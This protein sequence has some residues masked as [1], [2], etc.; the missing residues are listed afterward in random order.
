MVCFYVQNCVTFLHSTDLTGLDGQDLLIP[1]RAPDNLLSFTLTWTF[2]RP[3]SRSHI[4]TFHSNTKQMLNDWA[5]AAEL[6]QDRVRMGDG[7]LHLKHF[8][9]EHAGMYTC[10]FTASQVNHTVQIRVRSSDSRSTAQTGT[11]PRIMHLLNPHVCAVSLDFYCSKCFVDVSRSG[12]WVLVI[13]VAALI[14][15]CVFFFVFKKCAGNKM[16]YSFLSEHLKIA[17]N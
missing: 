15:L 14:L 13:I 11:K 12:L 5:G 3:D 10:V 4:L 7:S 6:N 9:S 16:F 2:T 8:V 1:C 17:R